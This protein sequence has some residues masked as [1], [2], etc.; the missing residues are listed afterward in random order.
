MTEQ[1]PYA[2]TYVS[3]LFILCGFVTLPFRNENKSKADRQVSGGVNFR[4]VGKAAKE[5]CVSE[6]EPYI[7]STVVRRIS[8]TASAFGTTPITFSYSSS[9]GSDMTSLI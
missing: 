9:R 1:F 3:D 7:R 6:A 5:R 4:G 8:S 2:F